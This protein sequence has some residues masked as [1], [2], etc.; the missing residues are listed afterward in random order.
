MLNEDLHTMEDQNASKKGTL[1]QIKKDLENID[2]E[3]DED[4]KAQVS[5]V[6]DDLADK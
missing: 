2:N 6:H 3:T 4:L 5:L 1:E